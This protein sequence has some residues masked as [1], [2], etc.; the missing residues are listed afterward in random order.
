[1]DRPYIFEGEK[2]TRTPPRHTH[3]K[4]LGRPKYGPMV[5]YLKSILWGRG[6]QIFFI[7]IGFLSFLLFLLFFPSFLLFLFFSP[8][9][10]FRVRAC[11]VLQH[12]KHSPPGHANGVSYIKTCLS[13]T[14]M[15]EVGLFLRSQ[16]CKKQKIK[17]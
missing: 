9:L 8:L 16:N 17:F 2:D 14:T 11:G 12:P 3:L 5:G 6:V 7:I 4:L 15:G 13:H 10:F 1:M